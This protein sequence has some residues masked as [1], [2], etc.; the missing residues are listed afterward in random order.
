[1]EL[2]YYIAKKLSFSK[3]QSF[4]KSITVLAI[5]AVSISICVVILAFGILLGFKKEI[6]DKVSG[7]AGDISI[8]RYQLADGS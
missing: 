1:M 5:A 4:T 6:R 7:Y 3:Q 8:S 2:G